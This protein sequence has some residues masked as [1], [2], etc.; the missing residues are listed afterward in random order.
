[1]EILQARPSDLIEILYLLKVCILDMNQ[2]GLKHWNNTCPGSERIQKDLAGGLIYLAKEK[3]VCKGMITL[4][5][6][7]PEDYKQIAFN[8]VARKPL[9]LQRLAVHP[10]WQGK[11]IA[12]LLLDFAQ[13]AAIERGFDVVRLDVFKT[14]ET[15]RQ[16]CEKQRFKEVAPFHAA[17]Q[18]IPYLC[19][20]KK[21]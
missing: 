3:G 13:K 10:R 12:R 18:L 21:L 2:K 6:Q 19:F 9:Y 1:M 4:S 17:Y 14:S 8:P 15:A 16:F 20:E 11:G 5:D 7:E